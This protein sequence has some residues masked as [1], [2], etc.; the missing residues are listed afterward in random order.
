MKVRDLIQKLS[1]VKDLDRDVVMY[2]L[3]DLQEVDTNLPEFEFTSFGTLE[4]ADSDL[5]NIVFICGKP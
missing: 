1:E 3:I 5:D 2:S 4:I